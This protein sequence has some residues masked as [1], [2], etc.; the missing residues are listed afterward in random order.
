MVAFSELTLSAQTA[1]AQLFEATLATTLERDV[2][3]LRGSFARKRVKGR[4]YWYFQFTGL[5]G[6][7]HQVYVGPASEAVQAIITAHRAGAPG[8]T[9][10]PL[11]RSAEA[12]GVAPVHRRHYRVLRRLD[13]YGF[14]RAGGVLVG[15]HAFLGHG[16]MLGVRWGAPPRTEDLDFAHAGRNLSIALPANV[17]V[18]THAAIDSL[19]MGLLPV[20]TLSG[21]PGPSYVNPSE[22]EFRLDFL[23]PLHPG[24]DTPY[25]HASLHVTLQPLKFLEYLLVDVTQAV[26]F[27]ASG[28]VVTNVPNPARYALHKLLVQGERPQRL[29][30]KEAKDLHQAAALLAYLR[31]A[32]PLDVEEAWSDLIAR[33][34]GWRNRATKGVDALDRVAPELSASSWLRI[35]AA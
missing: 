25:E 6:K 3:G 12:L 10:E 11:A 14:F 31:Q 2:R 5:T 33:G 7:L 32:Q 28:A 9:L 20:R 17:E 27:C 29:R 15:T 8:T 13:E 4:E 24:H 34:P 30:T 21:L 18:D 35:D 26:M 16:N 1:Y 19:A 23:T 22:P